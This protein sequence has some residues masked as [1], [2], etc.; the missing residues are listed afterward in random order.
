M[1]TCHLRLG[2]E[3]YFPCLKH[4][5][6]KWVTAEAW[7]CHLSHYFPDK[8]KRKR[9]EA[10]CWD[11]TCCTKDS[12]NKMKFCACKVK[13]LSKATLK[14]ICKFFGPSNALFPGSIA[15]KGVK[16]K[17]CQMC[18]TTLQTKMKNCSFAN[19]TRKKGSH[20][21]GPL[22]TASFECWLGGVAQYA[23]EIQPL[24]RI[25]WCSGSK[26]DGQKFQV[27][28]SP[29]VPNSCQRWEFCFLVIAS[30]GGSSNCMNSSRIIGAFF[31]AR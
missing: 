8:K 21:C 26:V 17:I 7:R 25:W 28:Y 19:R 10:V 15:L 30:S 23:P 14:A 31:L 4:I 2:A 16:R 3:K 24:H 29:H 27:A 13:V 12:F 1:L 6:A 22:W 18:I 20:G 5:Q 11:E 9:K